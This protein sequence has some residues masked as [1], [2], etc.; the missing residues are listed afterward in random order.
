MSSIKHIS[1]SG[2]SM[3]PLLKEG[4]SIELYTSSF[5]ELGDI[6]LT[7]QNGES[8]LHRVIS[9]N[10]L[11]TMGDWSSFSDEIISI[12]APYVLAK[13]VFR[14][15]YKI[16]LSVFKGFSAFVLRCFPRKIRQVIFI[17]EVCFI[18]KLFSKKNS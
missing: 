11:Q 6:I 2:R 4:D 14:K 10:P 1:Y 13:F 3:Y 7:I 15:D 5:V 9:L 17:F 18:E 8:V 16:N 12:S